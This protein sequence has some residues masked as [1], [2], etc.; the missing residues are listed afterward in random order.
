MIKRFYDQ[1]AEGNLS[2]RQ[3]QEQDLEYIQKRK[4]GNRHGQKQK[5]EQK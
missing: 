2:E 3:E 5:Q 4:W 1:M